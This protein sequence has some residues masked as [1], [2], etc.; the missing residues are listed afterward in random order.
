MWSIDSE[1]LYYYLHGQNL[2][3][4]RIIAIKDRGL[5]DATFHS[6]IISIST[7][8]VDWESEGLLAGY[9]FSGRSS[10]VD[11][12]S[13]KQWPYILADWMGMVTGYKSHSSILNE[14]SSSYVGRDEADTHEFVFATYL[15]H[16]IGH[17]QRNQIVGHL[18]SALGPVFIASLGLL[19]I[20]EQPENLPQILLA[21][22]FLAVLSR[23]MGRALQEL[24]AINFTRDHVEALSEFV[25]YEAEEI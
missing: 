16:E 3:G 17:L 22:T 23:V 19:R 5:S 25:H 10:V 15:A 12:L 1:D 20:K 9:T 24:Q 18:I 14:G 8:V 13:P 21:S 11:Y 4:P 2:T 6:G 7:E